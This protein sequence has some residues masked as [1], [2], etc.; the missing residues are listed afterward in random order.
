[1]RNVLNNPFSVIA[2]YFP[3][4]QWGRWLRLGLIIPL[5]LLA[6]LCLWPLL[7]RAGQPTFSLSNHTFGRTDTDSQALALGDLDGDGDLDIFIGEGSNHIN[8]VWLNDGQGFYSNSGQGLGSSDSRA[9]ALGDLDGDG[10]LDAFVGNDGRDNKVWLNDGTGVFTDTGQAL[11]NF[12]TRAVALGDLN[13]DGYLD[14][15]VGNSSGQAN[16]VWLNDGQGNFPVGQPLGNANTQ[17]VALGDLDGDG[18]L[19]AFVANDG[20]NRIWLNDGA[21]SFT[22]VQSLGTADSW[23]VDLGDLDGDGDLDAFVANKGSSGQPN[24]VWLNDGQGTFSA[25]QSLGNDDSR[26]VALG[27]L[28]GDGDLDAFIANFSGV[29]PTRDDNIVWQNDGAANFTNTAQNL[30]KAHTTAVAMGDLDGDG[31][32]DVAEG[33]DGLNRIWLN[34]GEDTFNAATQNL[35][36][37]DSVSVALGDLDSDNDL[38]ALVGNYTGQANQVWL[39]DGLGAFTGGQAL[40]NF[41]TW[42]VVLGDL[43]G[44]GYLDAFTGNGD[45]QPSQIWLNSGQGN[46]TD[47]GQALG[48]FD[49]TAAALGDLDSDGDLD[50][51]IGNFSGQAN[52]VWLNNGQANFTDSGQKLGNSDSYDV[53][54]GDLDSDGDLDAFVANFTGQANR[55][56]F[57]DGQANFT[58]SGQWLGSSD[59]YGLALG[60][61]DGDGDLDAFVA[62]GWDGSNRVWLNNGQGYFEAIDQI[63]DSVDSFDVALGDID[64]DGDQDAFV[65]NFG[66]NSHMLWLNDGQANFSDSGQTMALRDRRAVALGDLNNDGNLDVFAAI[67]DNEAN[68]VYI[69][70]LGGQDRFQIGLRNPGPIQAANF[71]ATPVILDQGLVPFS[72]TLFHPENEPLGW[73]KGFYSLD[74]GDNWQ[75]A[76]AANGTITTNLSSGYT[77]EVK[78]GLSLVDSGAASSTLT[79]SGVDR[80]GH[81]RVGL[82]ISHTQSSQLSA[83]LRSSWPAP[84]GTTVLLFDG[85]GGNSPGFDQLILSDR[86]RYRITQANTTPITLPVSGLYKP[87]QPLSQFYGAPL[88]MPLTLVISDGV[89]GQVGTLEQW[90]VESL[91]RTHPYTWDAFASG[92]FGQSDHT[93]FRLEAYPQPVH[94]TLPNS[95]SYINRI[96]G[97]FR[98]PFAS[99]ATFPFRVRGTQVRVFSETVIASNAVSNAL[100]YRLP[101]NHTSG[102]LPLADGS[103]IPFRTNKAGYLQ[104]RGHIEPNDWLVA[105]LPIPLPPTMTR[106]YSDSLTLYHTSAS[107]VET[108]LDMATVTALGVQTLTVSAAKPLLLFDLKVSLEWDASKDTDFIA[109]LKSDLQRASEVLFDATNGQVALGNITIYHNQEHW[110]DAHL[111]VYA[112]NQLRPN[113]DLGGVRT[114]LYTD[115]VT[116]NPYAE[117]T[118]PYSRTYGPGQVRMGAVWNR[119]G[120]AEG[121]I[122]EDWPRTLVH[123]L[124]HYLFY[125]DEDYLGLDTNGLAVS[126][127]GCDGTVMNDPYRDD[128]SE[129]H[130]FTDWDSDC[131]N[132]LQ[133]QQNHRSDWETMAKFYPW[134]KPDLSNSGPSILPIAVTQITEVAPTSNPT[135]TLDVPIFYTTDE[136][137]T[138][139]F[140][141]NSA[142]A[143]LYQGERLIDLGAPSRDKVR[144]WGAR[145]GDR[146]CVYEPTVQRLGCEIIESGDDQLALVEKSG[147]QPQVIVTPIT[148][149]TVAI[150]VTL[151][152]PVTPPLKGRLYPANDAATDPITLNPTAQPTVYTGTFT[153]DLPADQGYIQV[154]VD[155][156][157]SRREMITSYSLGGNPGRAVLGFGRAV[158]GF[159]RAV[160]GFGRTVLGFAPVASSDGQVILFGDVDFEVGQFY[161]LQK[162]ALLPDPPP[163]RTPIGSGYYLLASPNAPSFDGTSLNFR[164]LGRDVPPG[165]EAFISLY[166]WDGQTWHKLETERN[167]DFN[168][169]SALVQ[170]P[171]LYALMSSFE[172]PLYQAGWNLIAYPVQ[173]TRPVSEALQSID[174]AY[175]LVYGYEASDAADP[176]RIYCNCQNEPN[177]VATFNDLETLEFGQGYWISATTA[178]TLYLEGTSGQPDSRAAVNN[179][180]NPPA[181][182]YGSVD[183]ALTTTP[184]QSVTAWIGGNQCGQGETVD[185][186][187]TLMYVVKVLSDG[188][189][190]TECG[191]S[192]RTVSFT[193]NGIAAGTTAWRIDKVQEFNLASVTPPGETIYLPVIRK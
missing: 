27:D 83:A 65:G 60:D 89:A 72:Y 177:W 120:E 81:L 93:V 190:A 135:A 84:T 50:L 82:S 153:L 31:D 185:V 36:N 154:W 74:G 109:N 179:F 123:E 141:G 14:A 149:R 147:W 11:G 6:L 175:A 20:A 178:I 121:T 103:G 151:A 43:N 161:A 15:F 24:Q 166:Y 112:T 12:D 192:G 85:I 172:I 61:L 3:N 110:F 4:R 186:N 114:D 165:E 59:S 173:E 22:E 187:G 111:R 117:Q 68:Q 34:T 80:I 146:L 28:D 70:Q 184:G 132:T 119:F 2:W 145:P 18:D 189:G 30:G 38:D 122:G 1:M 55:V 168:E 23:A 181:T 152:N 118:L 100:V 46:F 124:G 87:L 77:A 42:V 40:G 56:W 136:N 176:W 47:S 26:A 52:Q 5:T 164:Y 8:Q 73:V 131:T 67:D 115:V 183:P 170:G 180:Q 86:A 53:A 19:D 63:L 39:N 90:S 155:E 163:G 37:S 71:F 129:F 95:Y 25:G 116:I 106:A 64:G 144:T 105:L 33:N 113:A 49:T 41:W 157:I 102:G 101:A 16:R 96:P 139:Y 159:G 45:P 125:L 138:T 75:P 133:A 130:P 99:A 76:V 107:P 188:P 143:I 35:G 48:N 174:G 137:G 104:G 193:V 62:N 44:N 148:S 57:N 88:T 191:A 13:G 9:V 54:L 140:P 158:L 156:G 108:G 21:G 78:P 97:P 182:Y 91:G 7:A 17:G 160:L 98:W 162:A 171:G 94:T 142:L 128:F 92:V 10:D 127:T 29:D 134:L 51:F 79:F 58:D 126:V 167:P 66:R 150:S 32:L 69:S 169:A